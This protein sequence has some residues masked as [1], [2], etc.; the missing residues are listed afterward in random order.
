[1]KKRKDGSKNYHAKRNFCLYCEK[2]YAKI[3]RHLEQKHS[4]ESKVASALACPKKSKERAQLTKKRALMNWPNSVVSGMQSLK[5]MS[6][7]LP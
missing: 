7:A 6:D 1:M 4:R 3:A 5:C 2:S